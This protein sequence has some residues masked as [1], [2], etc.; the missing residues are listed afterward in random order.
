MSGGILLVLVYPQ[1]RNWRRPFAWHYK[2]NHLAP[3]LK[4]RGAAAAAIVNSKLYGVRS[5]YKVMKKYG[6]QPVIGLSVK[7][8][9]GEGT[10]LFL[11]YVYAKNDEGYRNLL[12]MS[13]AISI[14]DRK[15]FHY[16]GLK[17]IVRAVLSFAR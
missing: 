9:V 5:F 17:L 16:S 12:K 2:L 1:I 8:E 11:L 14:R 7:L 13:S 10:N 4:R 6:I 3:L 15:H